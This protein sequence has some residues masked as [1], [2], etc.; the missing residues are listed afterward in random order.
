MPLSMGRQRWDEVNCLKTKLDSSQ[1][2]IPAQ[3]CLTLLATFNDLPVS[4]NLD[5]GSLAA[6]QRG[7]GVQALQADGKVQ[8][9]RGSTAQGIEERGVQAAEAGSSQMFRHSQILGHHVPPV[10]L[11]GAEGLAENESRAMNS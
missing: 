6:F 3:A 9:T 5:L 2:R 1:V 10:E 11:G 7:S 8:T 4:V